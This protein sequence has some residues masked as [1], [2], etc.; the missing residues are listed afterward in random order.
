MPQT[1]EYNGFTL[2]IAIEHDFHRSPPCSSQLGYVAVVRICQPGTMLSWFSPLR[3]GEAGG[4]SF[5]SRAEALDGGFSA[6]QRMVDDL[7]C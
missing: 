1:Y 5:A 6:A 3:L 2:Q 7:L 4:R